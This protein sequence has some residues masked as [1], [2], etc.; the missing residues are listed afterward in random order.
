MFGC[1]SAYYIIFIVFESELDLTLYKIGTNLY[2]LQAIFVAWV[3]QDKCSSSE[4]SKN[5][6]LST[7]CSAPICLSK[8][9]CAHQR[10]HAS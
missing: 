4:T 1:I 7:A 10:A 2:I 9:Q 5:F 3:R 6:T 8:R